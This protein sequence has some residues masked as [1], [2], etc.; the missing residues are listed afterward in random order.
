M[1]VLP[2]EEGEGAD[3]RPM[4]AWAEKLMWR[5]LCD[6]RFSQYKLRRQHRH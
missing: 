5:W 6:R 4:Q 3:G 2:G 1:A